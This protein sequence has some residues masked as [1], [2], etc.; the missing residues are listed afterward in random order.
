LETEQGIEKIAKY[1]PCP[2]VA[3]KLLGISVTQVKTKQKV[4][5]QATPE[6]RERQINR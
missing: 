3:K 1:I 5:S 2:L 4:S 6:S